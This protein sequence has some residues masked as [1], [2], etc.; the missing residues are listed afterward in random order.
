MIPKPTGTLVPIRTRAE[1]RAALQ[2]VNCYIIP[3]PAKAA[4]EL[5]LALR[6]VVPLHELQHLRRLSRPAFIPVAVAANL[7][8]TQFPPEQSILYILICTTD[9]APIQQIVDV[10][11][12]I[13]PFQRKHGRRITPKPQVSIITVPANMPTSQEQS[14]LWSKK[15]WPVV[16]KRG[17][18]FGPH[19]SLVENTQMKLTRAHEYME[20][21]WK[22]AH[23]V[24]DIG[25]G[26]RCG[27]VVVNPDTG[28]VIAAA[29]DAR[30]RT[31]ESGWCYPLAH[32]V[33]RL[34]EMVAQKRLKRGEVVSPNNPITP[35]TET[36][37][38]YLN[39]ESMESL[40]GREAQKEA[41]KAAQKEDQKEAQKES[42]TDGT[43][44]DASPPMA[45][46]LCHNMHI[47]LTHEPCVMCSMALLHSRVGIV[48]FQHRMVNSGALVSEFD[49]GLGHGLFWR[50]DLNWKY[51]TWQWQN[52]T[53]HT[54]NEVPDNIS[55]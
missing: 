54:R 49:G 43:S 46:Y 44:E 38:K 15:Y 31:N 41:Q 40:D 35:L 34:V 11:A 21:A 20:I 51:L 7:P 8:P 6:D 33:M 48:V 28:D 4:N 32:P 5:I 24:A 2:T 37:R 13:S 29:G 26:H 47:Y 19:P 23:E 18:P 10:A 17:N 22:V 30:S 55:A 36:E 42:K 9:K 12:K 53:P 25:I 3:I 16:Y 1:I 14:D 50:P 27:A 45:N 39:S 52:D